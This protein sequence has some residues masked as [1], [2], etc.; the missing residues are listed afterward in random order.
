M[1]MG[2]ALAFTTTS[3]GKRIAWAA[4]GV[5]PTL[6][7]LPG[8]PFSDL[9]A[10]WRIPVLA[11]A[12]DRMARELRL[13][14]YDGRGT[15][16]SERHIVD[17]SLDT[18]L[19]DL[20][21]VV[22]SADAERFA[23]LGFYN[24]CPVA[25]A[26]AAR[27][28]EQVTSVILFGASEHPADSMDRP[29]TEAL[30][31]LIDRDWDTFAESAAHAWLGWPDD[32]AGRLAADW[33]RSSTTP[34]VASATLR[35]V[36]AIDIGD[37]LP[38]IDCPVLVLHRRD[39]RALTLRAAEDVAAKLPDGRLRIIEG[40]S[41]GLYFEGGS[42]VVDILCEFVRSAASPTTAPTSIPTGDESGV[43][44]PITLTTRELDVLRLIAQGYS[45]DEI[46][47]ALSISVNTVERHVT[48]TYRKI[49][50]RARADATAYAIRRGLA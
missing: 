37:R 48:N 20:E 28:P 9:S 29:G 15:G 13:V 35:A 49:G 11:S 36:R 27:H 39:T 7:S 2:P 41:A 1:H 17:V 31:S 50:A 12:Y 19:L 16:H 30:L 40:S 23:L 21:A 5:G 26:Y 8:I 22:R 6:I 3:D 42:A 4:T 24:S 46:A 47:H 32:E 34:E 18:M 10:E 43:A 44:A 33:V 38:S 45:N 25:L 14:Q